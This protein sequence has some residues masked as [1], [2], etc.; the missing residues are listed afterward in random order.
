[1]FPS[2]I[3][4]RKRLILNSARKEDGVYKTVETFTLSSEDE[5][6]KK[7]KPTEISVGIRS[8]RVLE[9]Q[10]PQKEDSSNDLIYSVLYWLDERLKTYDEQKNLTE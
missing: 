6:E 10:V 9:N 2:S 3:A 7:E 1:M 4:S 8:A 5:K